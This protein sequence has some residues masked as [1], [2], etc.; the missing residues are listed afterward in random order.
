MG[1][2]D[3]SR[4]S[5][6][7]A[8]LALTS[9]REELDKR[10][11]TAGQEVTVITCRSQVTQFSHDGVIQDNTVSLCQVVAGLIF[12]VKVRIGGAESNRF[13]HLRVL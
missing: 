8:S 10:I 5:D 9:V 12:F 11:G 3:E 1:A 13:A 7:A 2:V 6:E 4:P